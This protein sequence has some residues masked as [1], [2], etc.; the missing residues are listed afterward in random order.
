MPGRVM[1]EL[2]RGSCSRKELDVKVVWERKRRKLLYLVEPPGF[3]TWLEQH[4]Q[5]DIIEPNK[6]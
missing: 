1:P 4:K 3:P 6:V 5:K 2:R